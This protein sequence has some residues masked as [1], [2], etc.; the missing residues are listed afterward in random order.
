MDTDCSDEKAE[1]FDKLVNAY[2][3]DDEDVMQLEPL[4]D[5]SSIGL[6]YE[7]L[8]H[9]KARR[10]LPLTKLLATLALGILEDEHDIIFSAFAAIE[11]RADGGDRQASAVISNLK[12]NSRFR[13]AL[14]IKSDVFD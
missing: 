11:E 12:A 9:S 5:S 8:L 14:R 4:I 2:V 6:R 10:E 1:L 13:T 3:L 7:F